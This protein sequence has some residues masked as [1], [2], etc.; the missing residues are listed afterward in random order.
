M[1]MT[2]ATIGGRLR[3]ALAEKGMSLTALSE[4]AGLVYSSVQNYVANKQSPRAEAL[5]KIARATK[6]NLNWLLNGDGEMF[7]ETV[8]IVPREITM[9][10]YQELRTR[11]T[12]FDEVFTTKNPYGF[13]DVK[14]RMPEL[15]AEN[16][17]SIIRYM[18]KQANVDLAVFLDG[19]NLE[20]ISNDELHAAMMD[21]LKLIPARQ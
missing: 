13:A 11:F 5:A 19:R 12:N 3:E 10:D 9:R 16:A 2:E 6:I 18:V 1:I 7:T 17:R 15:D 8:S 20:T 14:E 4:V 21:T